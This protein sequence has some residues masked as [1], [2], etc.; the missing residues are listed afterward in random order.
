MRTVFEIWKSLRET[1]HCEGIEIAD[2][3]RESWARSEK[4]GVDPYKRCCDV[5]LSQDELEERRNQNRAFYEQGVIMMDYLNQI[6]K[7]DAFIFFFKTP[8]TTYFI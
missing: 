6:M 7:E 3:I 1:G 2:D 5:I 4:Y 8:I